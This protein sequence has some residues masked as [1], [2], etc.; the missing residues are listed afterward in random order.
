MNRPVGGSKESRVFL[1]T[2]V[3]LVC[4]YVAFRFV[5][6]RLTMWLGLSPAPAPIPRFAL[7]IYMV[8]AVVG[9]LIYVS[10]DEQRWHAFLTPIVRLFALRRDGDLR[11]NL[12]VLGVLPLLAGWIGW[13][14]VRPSTR[15]SAALR[16]QHPTL[17][18]AYAEL[19][20]PFRHLPAAEQ[21]EAE[22]EGVVLYQTNCRPCHGTSADGTGPLAR[23]LRLQPVDFTDAGTIA[24]L[25]ESY[26]FWRIKEGALGL[27]RIATPWNSVMPAWEDELSEQDIWKIIMA[28]YRIAGT[29]PRTPERHDP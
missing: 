23:G 24:T 18:G 6:P 17:P 19:D 10:S 2:G 3:V 12:L 11:R 25:V 21:Q 8:S 13:Q 15:T 22:K 29:E 9:A 1:W 14:Q 4:L 26:P 7:G 5:A 28:E 16:V 20:N 27:A